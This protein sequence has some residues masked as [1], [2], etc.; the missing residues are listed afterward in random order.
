MRDS[1]IGAQIRGS[2]TELSKD[3]AREETLRRWR[4]LPAENRQTTEQAQ[5]FA[6]ALAGEL[7]FRTMANKRKVI[8]SWLTN[9]MA[10]LPPWGRVPP[11]SE[12]RRQADEDYK[13]AAE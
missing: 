11:E 13:L 12:V 9:E 10:G 2:L 8:E 7:D 4:A 6:A 5:F 3:D 1:G